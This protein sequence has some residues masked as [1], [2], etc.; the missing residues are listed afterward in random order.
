MKLD[1]AYG[2]I[3][4]QPQKSHVYWVLWIAVS[5][6][7]HL[8]EILFVVLRKK[9]FLSNLLDRKNEHLSLF[10]RLAVKWSF[11]SRSEQKLHFNKWATEQLNRL[12]KPS[13]TCPN[14]LC[15]KRENICFH[16]LIRQHRMRYGITI[17]SLRVLFLYHNDFLCFISS[18][19]KLVLCKKRL[20]T[21][22]T[23]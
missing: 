14:C 9:L 8:L 3:Y 18:Y 15:E 5:F 11:I 23:M 4:M 2:S 10:W 22:K 13:T 16:R 1:L 17:E 12:H 7:L 19:L 6:C 20:K 21:S